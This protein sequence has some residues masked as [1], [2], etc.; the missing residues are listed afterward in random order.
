MQDGN[1]F[2]KHRYDFTEKNGDSVPTYWKESPD[3]RFRRLPV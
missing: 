3:R 1:R 2:K